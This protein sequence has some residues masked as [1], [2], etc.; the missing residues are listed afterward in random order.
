MNYVR[1]YPSTQSLLS[2]IDEYRQSH[3]FQCSGLV[4]SVVT[5]PTGPGKEVGCA[6]AMLMPTL[7]KTVTN[8]KLIF[9]SLR[10]S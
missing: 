9:I 10:V 4:R 6:E 7:L 2:V 1:T 3:S 5:Q 8:W